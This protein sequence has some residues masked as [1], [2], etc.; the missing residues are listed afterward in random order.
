[1]KKEVVEYDFSLISNDIQQLVFNAVRSVECSGKPSEL[2]QLLE[3]LDSDLEQAFV[4]KQL[5]DLGY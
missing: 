3:L 4:K 5:A 1:M 2:E